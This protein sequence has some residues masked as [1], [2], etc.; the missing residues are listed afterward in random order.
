M[1]YY[2]NVKKMSISAQ[3]AICNRE[4]LLHKWIP[5]KRTVVELVFSGR[6]AILDKIALLFSP[7]YPNNHPDRSQ[8]ASAATQ[9]ERFWVPFFSPKTAHVRK[10]QLKRRLI[11]FCED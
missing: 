5:C 10:T 9:G 2:L 8:P 1:P 7:E 4:G 6:K 11:A 3:A